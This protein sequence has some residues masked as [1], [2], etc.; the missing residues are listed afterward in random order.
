MS[1]DYFFRRIYF[2]NITL[3]AHRWLLTFLSSNSSEN[4][5]A[6]YLNSHLSLNKFLIYTGEQ[7]NKKLVI[8]RICAIKNSMMLE[9]FLIKWVKTFTHMYRLN[10]G[11][12][13][14]FKLSAFKLN[15]NSSNCK[16]SKIIQNDTKLLSISWELKI[17][18]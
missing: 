4:C 8:R 15:L 10:S 18:I 6:E 2:K 17:D 1:L 13:W 14:I 5:R 11:I 3:V 16:A 7:I 12:L 9:T